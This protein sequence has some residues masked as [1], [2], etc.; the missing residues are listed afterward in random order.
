LGVIVLQ[1][2]RSGVLP[3]VDH[4]HVA[5]GEGVTFQA[6][7]APAV[8]AVVEGIGGPNKLKIKPLMKLIPVTQR[9][10]HLI[11]FEGGLAE[12]AGLVFHQGQ[13][14][15]RTDGSVL[16]YVIDQVATATGFA[17]SQR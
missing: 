12:G 16:R 15:A 9:V 8:I 13:Q 3:R 5:I 17:T 7:I 1:C 11:L 14:H 10:S 2:Y 4:H 6:A